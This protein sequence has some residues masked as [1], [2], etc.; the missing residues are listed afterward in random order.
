MTGTAGI[1]LAVVAGLLVAD[2]RQAV[3]VV[4][5]PYVAVLAIQTWGIAAGRGVSPPSTVTAF[6]GAIPYY[7]VQA[8]I[9][10]LALGVALQI[11]ALTGRDDRVSHPTA[12][13]LLNGLIVVLVLG[14]FELDRPLFDPG[15]V[16]Q[17]SSNGSPPVLGV[18][19]IALLFV[20][21]AALGC[22][23]LRR[24]W[25]EDAQA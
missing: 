17:H 11:R 21:F 22:L 2:K 6:P 13:Y 5:Y 14:A 4:V 15:S 8:V 1:L 16:S 25:S 20:V 10:A 23:T 18:V 19:G 9:L 24:R 12:A 3:Q 7:L